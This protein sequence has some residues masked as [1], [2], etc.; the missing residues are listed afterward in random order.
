MLTYGTMYAFCHPSGVAEPCISTAKPSQALWREPLRGGYQ[1]GRI[2]M[3]LWCKS[4]CRTDPEL[5]PPLFMCQ[6]SVQM[7]SNNDIKI[8]DKICDPNIKVHN[9]LTSDQT[10]GLDSWKESLASIFKGV[11]LFHQAAATDT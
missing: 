1:L 2:Y 11:H 5:C 6:V 10:D 8:A 9:L 7:F 4:L 3:Q